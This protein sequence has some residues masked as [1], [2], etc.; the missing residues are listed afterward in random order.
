MALYA[1]LAVY[2]SVY[3]ELYI[4]VISVALQQGRV[5]SGLLFVWFAVCIVAI[6]YAAGHQRFPP[7]DIETTTATTASVDDSKCT[8]NTPVD[9]GGGGGGIAPTTSNVAWWTLPWSTLGLISLILTLHAVPVFVINML[10]VYSTTLNY[11]MQ[12]LTGI[13]LAMACFKLAWN[14]GFNFLLFKYAHVILPDLPVRSLSSF[15]ANVGVFNLIVSPILTESLAS[16]NCFQYAFRAIPTNT[17][18]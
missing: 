1:L 7:A 12:R 9:G 3:A 2:T 18:K 11:S 17:A 8:T 13:V 10:Y 16:P 6:Q 5:A 15:L 4:W 14:G